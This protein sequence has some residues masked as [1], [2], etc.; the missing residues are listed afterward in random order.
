M[1][2]VRDKLKFKDLQCEGRVRAREVDC[3]LRA[4]KLPLPPDLIQALVKR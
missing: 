3:T 1:S 2:E 4:A